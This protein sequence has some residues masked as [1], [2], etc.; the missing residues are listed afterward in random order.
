MHKLLITLIFAAGLIGSADPAHAQEGDNPLAAKL[1][2]T[3]V[4]NAGTED[5]AAVDAKT[6]GPGDI[7]E[8]N[9][10]YSNVSEEPLE[11]IMIEG[12][13]PDGTGYVPDATE[14]SLAATFQVLVEGEDWQELPAYKTIVLEDGTEERVEA[15]PSD[16]VQI[17]WALEEPL[18]PSTTFTTQYRV[19]VSQ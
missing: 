16:Y 19:R 11:G 3:K 10:S 7:L 9:G 17:R 8:Y 5:E 13:I 6:A 2:V 1:T 14:A 18:A 12:P 15:G 4:V